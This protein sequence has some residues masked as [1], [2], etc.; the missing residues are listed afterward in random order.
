M[1]MGS[2]RRGRALRGL[3]LTLCLGLPAVLG[4]VP[5]Q[6]T[7]VPPVWQC[8]GSALWASLAG[9]NRV[10]PIVANGNPNT[11]AN[12]SPDRPQCAAAE[13]G[14]EN[15]ASPLGLPPDLLTAK[16]ASAT[17]AITPDLGN[18]IE[19]KLLS[20][21]KIEDLTLQLPPGGS[22]LVLGVT[23]AK[24]QATASCSG[25]TP[26]LDGSS[27]VTGLS[28]N[29]QGGSLDQ[30][31]QQLSDGLQPL[32]M[33]ISIKVNEQVKDA[34]SL[35]QRALHISIVNQADMSPVLELVVGEAKVAANG[36]VCNPQK[37]PCPAGFGLDSTLTCV[38]VAGSIQTLT[39]VVEATKL[40][41]S[42]NGRNGGCGHITMYFDRNRKR[43]FA[44]R[45]GTRVVTRGRLVNCKGK[46]IVGAKIDVVHIIHGHRRLIKTGLKSRADGR[47][48]LIL[49][50]NLTTRSIE[51]D[52]RG[53]LSSRRVSS[54]RT[55]HL[56]VR[57][58]RGRIVR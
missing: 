21:G 32:G 37:Q 25:G 24:A 53:H 27:Q 12:A 43:T 13:D 51:Y 38:P 56:T 36:E 8:R 11:A 55:L 20:T 52:Y 5:A 15:M 26:K 41:S 57:N 35:T 46:P 23:L 30:V 14:L 47:L 40:K 9:N 6:A 19:Q 3:L 1:G 58:R 49:P 4:T 18:P 22:G 17:T 39:Q 7:T 10:E 31:L 48:T 50:L 28:V 42:V 16:T 34:A 45:Y 33:L 29:G 2:S 54:R 44:S